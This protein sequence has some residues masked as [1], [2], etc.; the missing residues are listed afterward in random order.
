M[1]WEHHIALRHLRIPAQKV[2][3]VGFPIAVVDCLLWGKAHF[4]YVPSFLRCA[5]IKA[6]C[7]RVELRHTP[8][9]WHTAHG[10]GFVPQPARGVI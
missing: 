2:G 10:K 6:V 1:R 7:L 8:E 3:K 5:E 9:A 4:G